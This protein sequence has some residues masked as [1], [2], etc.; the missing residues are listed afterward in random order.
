MQI[1]FMYQNEGGEAYFLGMVNSSTA[2]DQR[3]CLVT[4]MILLFQVRV[5]LE[6][7]GLVIDRVHFRA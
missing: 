5:A 6:Y 2:I 3:C 7:L 4:W 1:F